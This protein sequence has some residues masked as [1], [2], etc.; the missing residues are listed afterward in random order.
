MCARIYE[1]LRLYC[2]L[3]KS[4]FQSPLST[5]LFINHYLEEIR[6]QQKEKIQRRAAGV[7]QRPYWIPPPTDVHKMN[8]DA[9]VS[10]SN[11]RGVVGVICR[12][13]QGVFVGA[14]AVVFEGITD[15]EILEALA[16]SEALAL[17]TDL[18]LTK[19]KVGTGV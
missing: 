17:A 15:P 3:K 14:S 7:P 2:V 16:C 4:E 12:D 8:T 18:H 1:R 10:T 5:H 9:A 19:I 6:D 11:S 13:D